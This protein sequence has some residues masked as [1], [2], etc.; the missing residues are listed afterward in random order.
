MPSV[1]SSG[2]MFAMMDDGVWEASALSKMPGFRDDCAGH[3]AL[4]LWHDDASNA[5]EP[6]EDVCSASVVPPQRLG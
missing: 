6:L 2:W 4:Q 5:W 1:F 3:D